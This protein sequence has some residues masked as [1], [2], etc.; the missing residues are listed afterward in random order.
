MLL[1]GLLDCRKEFSKQQD[2]TVGLVLGWSDL[3]VVSIQLILQ[4]SQMLEANPV[5]T[6]ALFLVGGLSW[7]C[8][9]LL[10]LS[11]SLFREVTLVGRP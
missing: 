9:F 3:E 5:T 7:P 10:A 8:S 11:A 6:P 1:C 4:L 2:N